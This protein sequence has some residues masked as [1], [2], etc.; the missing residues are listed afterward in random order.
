[1]KILT[2]AATP[3]FSDR[4]CHMRVYNEAKYLQKLGAQVRIATYHNGKNIEAMDIV[5]IG[6]VGWYKKIT[7]GFAWGKLWLDWKMLFLVIKQLKTFEPQIIHAHLYEGLAI[8]HIARKIAG[9]NIPIIFDLQGDL[10]KEF[11]SYNQQQ[12]LAKS[13][14]NFFSKKVINWA[15][16]VI[17]SSAN[18]LAGTK[19]LYKNS[20]KIAV[21]KD[22]IDVELFSHNNSPKT[23]DVQ[24]LLDWKKGSKLLIYTGSIDES[25]GIA[26]LIAEF[27]KIAKAGNEWKLLIAGHGSDLEKLETAVDQNNLKDK[28]QFLGATDYFDLPGLLKM[29]DFAI[30]PKTESSESSGKLVNYM[31][32]GLPIVCYQNAFNQDF[33]QQNGYY[34]QSMNEL[35]ACLERFIHNNQQPIAYDLEQ[36]NEKNEVEKLDQIMKK[37]AV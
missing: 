20:Q 15:D 28:I 37:L 11:E 23:I 6:Q 14:F 5:R 26:S 1:M 32:A 17:L 18:S 12:N 9:K 8:G 21:I 16:Y 22:G 29:A 13:I 3:F 19:Q 10:E 24:P 31:A 2:I 33:L 30:D 34:I 36:W 7:P 35:G 4:G 25:K 27:S